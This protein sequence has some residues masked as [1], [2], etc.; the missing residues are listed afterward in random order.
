MSRILLTAGCLLLVSVPAMPQTGTFTPRR[1]IRAS[2]VG[3][4]SI[5]PDQAQVS[6]AVVTQA[7]TAQLAAAQNA[8]QT[9]AVLNAL[10]QLLGA[11][12]DL[13]TINYSL[14]PLYNYP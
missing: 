11:N 8:D 2:G 9:T 13:K 7:A 3:K 12:A 1:I 4:V 5:K 6:V 14:T 10:K